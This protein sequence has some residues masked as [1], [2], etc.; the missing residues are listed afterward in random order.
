MASDPSAT[1]RAVA[2]TAAQRGEIQT[3]YLFGSTATGRTRPD[4]DVDVAVLVA[5]P[6]TAKGAL[7]YR[8]ALMADLGAALRRPDIDVVILNDAPPLLA[9]RILSTGVLVFE[10]SRTARVRFQVRTAARYSDQVPMY[11]TQIR[12]L[13]KRARE[14]RVGG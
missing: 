8:L 10:R 4:S 11:E 9:H 12:Y 1:R 7:T 2:R 13:K 6:A 5:R 3:A 14:R